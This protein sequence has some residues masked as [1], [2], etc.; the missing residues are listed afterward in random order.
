MKFKKILP[1]T[2]SQRN[3]VRLNNSLLSKVSRIKKKIQGLKRK[4]GR[5]NSGKIT[6]RH[7]G[8]GAKKK[9]RVIDFYRSFDSLGVVIAIEYDPFRSSNIASI[10]D[11]L[12][13]KYYY[14]IS[15]MFL[16]V[17][18]IVGSG[19]YADVK[20]AHSLPLSKIPI[21][22]FIHSVSFKS[23][24]KSQV[25]RSA[26]CFSQLLEKNTTTARLKLSSGKHQYVSVECFATVG[27]VSNELWF[28]TTLGKAGRS[29]WLNKRPKVR[30]VA[31]NPIDHPHG[32]GEGKTSGGRSTSVTPW[33]K[34]TKNKKRSRTNNKLIIMKSN[35]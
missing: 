32:G 19:N 34:P 1:K 13:N 10:F 21:G 12:N 22:T 2:P 15:P 9:Y 33:G 24:K 29:R 30:G 5:N 8:G 31:M 6:S 25:S 35:N 3:L 27:I 18:Q 16:N 20:N 23:L 7:K 17:G 26:G 4:N 14:I 28:L 11:F